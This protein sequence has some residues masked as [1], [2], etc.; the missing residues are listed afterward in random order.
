M[1]LERE[2]ARIEEMDHGTGNIA[3][4]CLST[5]RQKKWIVLAPRR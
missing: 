5:L 1:G 3:P 4:E 2:V